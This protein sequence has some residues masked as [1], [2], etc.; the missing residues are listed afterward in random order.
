MAWDVDIAEVGGLLAE[1]ARCR[2]LLALADGRALPASLLAHEA[3]VAPSTAS[4]HLAR[5]IDAGW[6]DVEAH[7]R[8]RY[9]RLVNDDAAEIIEVASRLAP[10]EPVTSLTGDLERRRL[11][12]ARTCYRHLAGR[13]GVE[14]LTVFAR[15]GWVDGHDGS[16]REGVDRLSAPARDTI[17]Q[18]TDEGAARLVAL[19]IDTEPGAGTRHCVDWSE[20]RHH[21]GGVLGGRLADRLFALGWV[22]RHPAG[23]AVTVT[24]LGA[25]ALQ[26]ELGV[27]LDRL[28]PA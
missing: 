6:I 25:Q 22:E 1:P 4:G 17:Y 13:L 10:P 9:Y 26:D 11:R 15:D 19:G 16:F 27:D 8:Y 24:E 23:R 21:L 5:L 12:R 14:L 7:G 3:H 20:Q 28:D 2:I 18:V